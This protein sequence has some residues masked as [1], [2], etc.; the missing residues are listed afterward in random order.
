MEIPRGSLVPSFL[1]RAVDSLYLHLDVI[2]LYVIILRLYTL[3]QGRG[4]LGM[5][6]SWELTIPISCP[7]QISGA[8]GKNWSQCVLSSLAGISMQIASS[9]RSGIF[10]LHSSGCTI[11]AWVSTISSSC[12]S[13]KPTTTQLTGSSLIS[14]TGKDMA[15]AVYESNSMGSFN[16]IKAICG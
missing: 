8:P 1:R 9:Y 4:W 5:H 2:K 11:T 13:P 15:A 14:T 7:S 10:R 3:M 12:S 16:L 6:G